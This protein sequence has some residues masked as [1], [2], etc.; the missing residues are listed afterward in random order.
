MSHGQN[1]QGQMMGY[2]TGGQAQ[3]MGGQAGTAQMAAGQ[4]GVGGMQQAAG[5]NPGAATMAAQVHYPQAGYVQPGYYATAY[6]TYPHQQPSVLSGLTND[7]FLKGL[8]VG[9][10][11][12]YILTNESV[13]R[14]AI[15]GAVKAWTAVQGGLEEVK[16]RFQD[17]EAELHAA[18][19]EKPPSAG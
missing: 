8:L 1:Q 17:A 10:A 14:T 16:E 2:P 18:E 9:A 12:A 11:A 13:Q 15:K 3:A 4:M 6:Q 19:A 7:R 5:V